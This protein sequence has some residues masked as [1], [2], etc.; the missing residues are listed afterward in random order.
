[1]CMTSILD[2]VLLKEVSLKLISDFGSH[3]ALK[4]IIDPEV[5]E[6]YD[7]HRE[8]LNKSVQQLKVALDGDINSHAGSTSRMMRSNLQLIDEIN[9]QREQNKALKETVQALTGRLTHLARVAAEKMAQAEKEAYALSNG[10]QLPPPPNGKPVRTGSQ[11]KRKGNNSSAKNLMQN[12]NGF[13]PDFVTSYP[14]S[15]DKI[16]MD[17][18]PLTLL[19]KNRRRIMSLRQVISDL[20]ARI[21][22]QSSQPSVTSVSG[23]LLPP[24]DADMLSGGESGIVRKSLTD[25]NDSIDIVNTPIINS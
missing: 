10:L 1:M 5:N 24:I 3:G 21:V 9:K 16:G 8:F 12:E 17:T 15:F 19:E 20:E 14:E 22:L 2:P 6:E 25:F 13:D 18:N 11:K 7:R 23:T 4:T